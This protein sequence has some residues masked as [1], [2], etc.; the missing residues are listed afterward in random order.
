MENQDIIIDRIRKLL[1]MA[2]DASSPNEAAIA[3]GR[4]R[5]LMDKHQ[6]EASD[7][8]EASKFTTADAG[9]RYKFMPVWKNTLAVSV[10]KFNDCK[11]VLEFG[12]IRFQ[13]HDADVQV[14]VTMYEFLTAT[15]TRLCSDYMKAEGYG[16]YI[17]RIGDAFKKRAAAGVATKIAELQKQRQEDTKTAAGT[18]LVMFKMAAV[19][20]EFGD[21]R[22]ATK[23]VKTKADSEA[24]RAAA[25]GFVAGQSISINTQLD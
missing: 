18:S 4:A 17:A 22:Y 16:R 23:P 7:L 8:G 6:I 25:A 13:G 20:A 10:A 12:Q 9:S 11:A 24:S 21:T 3:A 5:K 15:I 2:A 19:V 14:A 1:A